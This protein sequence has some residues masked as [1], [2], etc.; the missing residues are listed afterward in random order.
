MKKQKLKNAG[1]A[2]LAFTVI[3]IGPVIAGLV[4]RWLLC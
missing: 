4:E 3:F 1:L 2:A